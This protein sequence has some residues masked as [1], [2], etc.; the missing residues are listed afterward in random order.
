MPIERGAADWLKLLAAPQPSQPDETAQQPT[1]QPPQEPARPAA[2]PVDPATLVGT[3]KA[4]R[5]DGSKFNLILTNDAKFTWSFA[6]KDQ[7][8]QTF[9]GTYSVEGNVLALERKDGGSLIG[10]VTPGGEATFNFKLLGAP[11]DDPGLAFSR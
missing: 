6:Q 10:E 5:A 9:G 7:A 1:P 8:A 2:K 4:A 11:D 3:W